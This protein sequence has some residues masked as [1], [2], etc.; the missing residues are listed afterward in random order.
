MSNPASHQ[1]CRLHVTERK[2]VT[3][4]WVD[5]QRALCLRCAVVCM[6]FSRTAA[7]L[8]SNRP[9]P[10]IQSRGKHLLLGVSVAY[11][12]RT[13]RCTCVMHLL[14]NAEERAARL[15]LRH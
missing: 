8:L 14:G 9:L 12:K 13:W 4:Y 15:P 5:L 7:V 1:N 11:R 2:S 6:C 10:N 3:T